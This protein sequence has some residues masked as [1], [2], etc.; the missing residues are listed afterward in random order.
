MSYDVVL[1]RRAE[2]EILKLDDTTFARVRAA[3][4]A[5]AEDPRPSGVR[6]LQGRDNEWRIRVGRY[7][8]LYA[9]EDQ[10]KRIVVYRVTDRKD[11][12]RH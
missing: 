9:V 4:D 2:R 7:R 3:I 12:Y 11:V 1:T 10:T 6:K 8:V 5:L